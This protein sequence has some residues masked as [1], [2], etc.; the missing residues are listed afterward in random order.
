MIKY[1]KLGE[2]ARISSGGTPSR[3]NPSYC[4]CVVARPYFPLGKNG[5]LCLTSFFLLGIFG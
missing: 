3:A 4:P 2:I 1:A 5:V